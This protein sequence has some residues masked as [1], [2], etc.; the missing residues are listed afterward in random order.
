MHRYTLCLLFFLVTLAAG[1]VPAASFFRG[2]RTTYLPLIHTSIPPLPEES[3]ILVRQN[4]DLAW[5]NPSNTFRRQL[6]DE[7]NN[8]RAQVSPDGHS[9]VYHQEN[10]NS[11]SR[12]LLLP[13]VGG[14]PREVPLQGFRGTWSPDSD[15]IAYVAYNNQSYNL[16]AYH[17]STGV[18]TVI[19]TNAQDV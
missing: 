7:G 4:Y 11:P 12:H 5:I 3:L 13:A 6:T 1:F 17:L 18:T 10:A 2:V 16:Y 8:Q 19:D 15:Y 9:V 14:T